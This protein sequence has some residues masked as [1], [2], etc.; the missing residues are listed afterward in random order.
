MAEQSNTNLGGVVTAEIIVLRLVHVLGGIFWVGSVT[1][2]GVFL[3]PTLAGLGPAA[4]P[5][6]AGLQRRRMPTVL[7]VV[8]VLTMLSGLRLLQLTSAGFSAEYFASGPGIAYSLGGLAAIAGFAVGMAFTRPAMLRAAALAGQVAG[9]AD[10]AARAA[11]GAE[12]AR[13]RSRGAKGNTVMLVLV[14]LAA[15]AMAVARYL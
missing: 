14:S 4:G 10:D 7:P 6:M 5:V 12:V 9:A 11:L 8:A 13:M 15:V 3:L 2:N 1:F